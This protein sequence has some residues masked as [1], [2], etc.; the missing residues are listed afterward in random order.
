MPQVNS[1]CIPC[2]AYTHC[3]ADPK[4]CLILS[5]FAAGFVE[6]FSVIPSI[7]ETRS[8]DLGML[9]FSFDTD[10]VPVH[11]EDV[12]PATLGVGAYG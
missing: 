12:I 11:S 9:A 8:S 5:V 7:R 2:S 10:F 1:L 4:S 3:F 6:E